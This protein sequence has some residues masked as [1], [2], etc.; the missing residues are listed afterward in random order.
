[1]AE[2]SSGAIYF[3]GLGNGTD[4]DSII[5]ATMTAESFRLTQLESW[6]DTWAEKVEVLQELN[7]EL[8]ALRTALK[9]MDT[10]AEFV[11]MDVSVSDSSAL[12]VTATGDAD[13]ANHTV[14]VGQLACNDI[15][16]NSATGEASSSD[17]ITDT[18]A[19]MTYSYGG[20]EYTID[21]PAGTTLSGLVNIINNNT[22]SNSGVR[23]AVLN[24]G[25]A[26]H[27][28]LYGMDQGADNA[29]AITDCSIEG[30]APEDFENTQVAKNAWLKVDGYPSGEDQWIERATNTVTDLLDGLTLNLRG[31]SSSGGV[32][33]SVAVDTDAMYETIVSFMDSLNTI[34]ALI[35][36]LTAVSDEGESVEGSI[37]TGNYGVD[38]IKQNLKSITASRALGF[39]YYDEATGSGDLFTSLAQIGIVTD[40]DE[41]SETFGM[42]VLDTD[43]G[44]GLTLI[45]ALAEDPLAVA[46]LFVADNEGVS[47][48][49]DFG[50]VSNIS[51]IT[52]P[53]DHE[54]AYEISGG[55]IIAATIN[56]EAATV[57]GNSITGAA[58]TAAAGMV[59]QVH[60][61]DDGSYTGTVRIKQ[62][63]IAEM[64]AS[65]A[66]ITDSESG[67][68]N[69][70]AD[71]YQTIVDNTEK[72]IAE[73][74]ARLELKE[75]T[76]RTM[77]AKLEATLSSYESLDTSLDS[78]IDQLPS[79]SS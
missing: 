56:G 23:A 2:Y 38:M 9:A 51:G 59:L 70:I 74:E 41:S 18:D 79:T 49:S 69:I 55:A 17:S 48:S 32:S 68:L 50:H 40:T 67:I 46:D 65:L 47:M 76:L 34:Y 35:D 33:V 21:V 19:T 43:P 13:V 36:E 4:F 44:A 45:Q 73:E 77:Y 26:Y 8:L 52:E 6:R 60:T 78:L 39:S 64:V 61:M 72:R 37:M 22:L 58:G 31:V 66:N 16:V 25:S 10:K 53:G 27:L 57:S 14:V 15:W 20:Q 42:L 63:T 75:R 7:T 24:D 30:Y 62:G 12:T 54:V 5:E 29:V 1:M 11:T 28:Q 3:T 71:N